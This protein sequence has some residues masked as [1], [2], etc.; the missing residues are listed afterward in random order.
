MQRARRAVGA[1]Q[2]A[3]EDD[4]CVK[5]TYAHV[6]RMQGSSCGHSARNSGRNKK[7]GESL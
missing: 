2:A 7:I 3:V 6:Y 5:G 1:Q 4:L